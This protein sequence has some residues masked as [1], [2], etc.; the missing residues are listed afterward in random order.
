MPAV[1]DLMTPEVLTVAPEMTLREAMDQ[2][3]AEGISGAPVVSA[4]G[5]VLGV[6]S[7]TDILDF[8]ASNPGGP[9]TPG[10]R[11]R[12]GGSLGGT[13]ADEDPSDTP[14]AWFIDLW[15][16]SSADVMELI[17]DPEDGGSDLLDQ[18]VVKE[19]MT[20]RVLSVSAGDPVA[21]AAE[22]MIESGVHRL[23]VLDEAGTLEGIL[24]TTDVVRAVAEG[25]VA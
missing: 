24:T 22:R 8:Q 3:V 15:G 23:L 21:K 4:G 18:H 19:V 1:R 11:E 5:R 16:E 2:L 10:D 14:S 6:V 17:S 20:S 9:R 25:R 13:A 12:W 7:A